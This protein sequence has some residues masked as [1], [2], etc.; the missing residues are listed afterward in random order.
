MEQHPTPNLH[1][2]MQDGVLAEGMTPVFPSKTFP[3]HYSLVTGLYTENTGVIANNMYDPKSKEW[4]SLGNREAVMN[5]NW[6]GG[7]PIWVTAEKQGVKAA[8]MFW[9]GSEAPIKAV[10]ATRWMPYDGNLPYSARVDSVIAWL[11]VQD[12]T[13][14]DFLTLY[15][16]GVDDY[17]H[18]YGPENKDSMAVAVGL[19]DSMIGYLLS[20]LE[21]VGWLGNINI[22]VTSDHGMAQLSNERVI[23][24][25]SIIDMDDVRM[26]DWNPVAMMYAKEGKLDAVYN[27][28]KKSESHYTVYKKEE[29]PEIYHVKN[30]DRVPDIMMVA[31]VGYAITTKKMFDER[32]VGGGTHGYD[33]RSKEMQALFLA[34]G[35]AFKQGERIPTFQN[36]HV[37]ELMCS[38]LGLKPAPNDGHPDSLRHVLR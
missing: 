6:Y 32:G 25:D 38:L 24:L 15:F 26:V 3:N 5:A 12:T 22:L 13:R 10:Y 21:R 29:I 36:I 28:L 11:S 27:A 37:Y 20:E 14:P 19:V 34:Y 33:N 1:R 18:R 31:D 7:E 30:N 16:S 9:P 35:P 23:L 17:G 8:T 4:F 2:L